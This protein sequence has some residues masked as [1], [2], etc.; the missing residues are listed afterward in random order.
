[1]LLLM[2]PCGMAAQEF[3]TQYIDPVLEG[4]YATAAGSVISEYQDEAKTQIEI[5]V[6]LTTITVQTAL[7]KKWEEAYNGYLKTASGFATA[8]KAGSHIYTDAVCAYINITQLIDAIKENPEGIASTAIL[9]DIY[10]DTAAELVSVF[11]ML[12]SCVDK[13]GEKNML[14]GQE[15]LE[16][17]WLLNDQLESLCE[18][19]RTLALSIRYYNLV[20]V[21]NAATSGI[22]DRSHAEIAEAAMGRWTRRMAQ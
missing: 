18:H 20:D 21:W 1:M 6:P 16:L 15:R 12:K 14:T 2:M 13:G 8:I 17:L 19:I 7:E 5:N 11:S 4:A 3:I 10:I 9:S 22:I